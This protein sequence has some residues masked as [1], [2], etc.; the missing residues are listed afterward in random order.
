MHFSTTTLFALGAIVSFASAGHAGPSA[1]IP[2]PSLSRRQT[3]AGFVE[4]PLAQLQLLQSEYNTFHGWLTAYLAAAG[5]TNQQAAQLNQ[6]VIAYDSWMNIFLSKY[7]NSSTPVG[8]TLSAAGG[9]SPMTG[10]SPVVG[11]SSAP[12]SFPLSSPS[13]MTDPSAGGV[14][15][16]V[17]ADAPPSSTASA[18]STPAPYPVPQ[19]TTNNSTTFNPSSPRNVAV[20][21]G[22][23]PHSN[24]VTVDELCK[25]PH[26]DI[27]VLAFLDTFFSDGGMPEINI[28]P[29]CSGDPTLGAQAINATGLLDCPYLAKNITTC[30]SL[31]KKIF[32]S[33]GGASGT[34]NFTSDTQATTFA[35]TVWNLF[36]GGNTTSNLRPF[37]SVTVDG[38]DI[39]NEDHST[40]HYNTFV[41]ALRSTFSSDTS[42]TYYI[43][44]AP[45]CPRPDESIPLAA[46]QSMDFV[47]VQF[48]NNAAANC[49]IGQPGFINSLKAWS[50]DL[51]GN[52]TTPGKGPKI[53]VGAPACEKC[54]GKGYL[55]PDAIGPVIKSAMTA[56]L[57]NF[58]GVMLWDGTEAKLNTA[59]GTDFLG[60]V[61][62][63]LGS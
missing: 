26:V 35:S 48:Y 2:H 45:Q 23:T 22:Q 25:D 29:A 52:S 54:A 8:A 58:G 9:T 59:N 42:K 50:G 11:S 43:S 15:I 60:V 44:S 19:N 49:D 46:M 5:P 51:S 33:L 55:A 17:V 38:F 47:F 1:R 31:G 32:L 57:T 40:D 53:Y 18:A 20:Y 21:Y 13:P 4:I 30:Q 36:G 28:G 12:T 3:P 6:D 16:S 10:M 27:V 37:G 14:D 62:G 24:K 56:N 41:S 61:K 63:A 39:D 7:S 34:T